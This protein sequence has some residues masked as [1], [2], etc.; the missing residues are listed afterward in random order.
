MT[1]IKLRKPFLIPLAPLPEGGGLWQVEVAVVGYTQPSRYDSSFDFTGVNQ[2]TADIGNV[3]VDGI[4]Y[5]TLLDLASCQA[6]VES[7]YYDTVDYILHVHVPAGVRLD[8]SDVNSQ[9]T[10]GFSSNRPFYSADNDEF[11]PYLKGDIT[12]E[13]EADRLVYNKMVSPEH[14]IEL[15]NSSGHFGLP[16]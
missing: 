9:E 16:A 13:D 14:T 7:F 11:L 4:K 8:S 1:I 10:F 2:S 12:I 5:E 3:Y 6:T 15:N